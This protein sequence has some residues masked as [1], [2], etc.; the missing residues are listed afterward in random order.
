MSEQ[1]R[2]AARQGDSY[3]PALRYHR[4]TPLYDMVQHWLTRELALKMDLV[5]Q[6]G[7]RGA[8]RVLDLGAGTGTLAILICR[9]HPQAR[10]VGLDAD[11]QIIKLARSKAQAAGVEIQW[12]EGSALAL[13]YPNSAF[14]RVVSSLMLHHLTLEEKV[15]AL[16]EVWR[17][18]RPGGEVHILDFGEPHTLGAWFISLA[19]RHIEETADE[20]DGLLTGI[21]RRAGFR[22]VQEMGRHMTVFGTL[23]LYKGT[24]PEKSKQLLTWEDTFEPSLSTY[25]GEQD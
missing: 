4:L 16:W 5:Q 15:D 13:P 22:E 24:K 1:V 20:I 25:G 7:I 3:I 8:H 18:L 21:M 23:T 17:V 2:T 12:D 10:V 11:P 6:A 9:T 19:M 14:D